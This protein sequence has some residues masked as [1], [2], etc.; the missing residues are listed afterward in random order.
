MSYWYLEREEGMIEKKLP[1]EEG[2]L[3]TILD[4]ALDIQLATKLGRFKCK[5]VGGNCYA[6]KPYELLLKGEG[7][8]VGVN[9]YKEDIYVLDSASRSD[10]KESEIL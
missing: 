1:D 9:N 3:N 8:F 4:Y 7:E 10:S 5:Q 2:I 6:C